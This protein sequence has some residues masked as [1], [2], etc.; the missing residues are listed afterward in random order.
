MENATAAE[1]LSD[2][3]FV[4]FRINSQQHSQLFRFWPETGRTQDFAAQEAQPVNAI[5]YANGVERL[6]TAE[7][8]LFGFPWEKIRRRHRFLPSI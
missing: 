1:T 7:A 3:S 5:S 8:V 2:G 4:A 6:G